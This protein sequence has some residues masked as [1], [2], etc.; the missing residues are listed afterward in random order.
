MNGRVRELDFLFIV[1]AITAVAVFASFLMP[2]QKLP[3]LAL[4]LLALIPRSLYAGSSILQAVTPSMLVLIV[5]FLRTGRDGWTSQRSSS[6]AH[7]AVNWLIILG[8]VWFAMTA[9]WSLDR[10]TSAGWLAPYLVCVV[11]LCLRGLDSPTRRALMKT[12]IALA[13]LCAVYGVA[14]FALQFNVIYDT[15]RDAIGNPL[16]QKWNSYRI[17]VSF[18]HPLYAALFFAV[19]AALAFG[20]GVATARK[21]LFLVAGLC[22]VAT[23]LTLSRAGIIALAAALV[24]QMIVAIFTRTTIRNDGK[25][26]L[27]LLLAGGTF[28]VMQIPQLRER[29]LSEEALASS[30]ARSDINNV[31]F[32]ALDSTS[33]V[34]SGVGTSFDGVAPYNPTE[35]LVE[36]GYFQMLVSTGAPGL[37]LFASLILS[38]ALVALR[39]GDLTSL[40]MITAYAL[41]IGSFN[42]IDS[43]PALILFLGFIVAF[44]L[45]SNADVKP[46]NDLSPTTHVS[47]QPSARRLN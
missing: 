28:G 3:S 21:R 12:W 40:G 32:S 9:L 25:I 23:A 20:A 13:A 24:L 11:L 44:A 1:V 17:N 37:V 4:A 31:V 2:A 7:R 38:V 19:S 10:L 16:V 18:G 27:A 22:A 8:F 26:A 35:L 15:I 6:A 34:G 5:W 30:A 33:Y 42:I 46:E 41:M 39:R 47:S 29:F 14:E 45:S 43:N 36:N